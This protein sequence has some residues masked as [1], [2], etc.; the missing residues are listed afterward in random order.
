MIMAWQMATIIIGVLVFCLLLGYGMWRVGESAD[1]ADHDLS[2]SPWYKNSVTSPAL[3]GFT[4]RLREL[5]YPFAVVPDIA[6]RLR[7]NH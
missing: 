4:L 7:P 5:A 3:P 6:L 1:R 2:H